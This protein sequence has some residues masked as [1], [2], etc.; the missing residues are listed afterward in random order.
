LERLIG[1][2]LARPAAAAGGG[3]GTMT[4]KQYRETWCGAV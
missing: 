1:Q 3:G 2:A 4:L